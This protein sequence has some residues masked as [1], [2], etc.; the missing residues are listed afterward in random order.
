MSP[1]RDNPS[2]V[3]LWAFLGTFFCFMMGVVSAGVV[4][5]VASATRSDVLFL[6]API[7]YFGVPIIAYLRSRQGF[8]P[9][10]SKGFGI[11]LALFVGLTLL[12][13]VVICGGMLAFGK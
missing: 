9:D 11:G 7:A 10:R 12:L 6:L 2:E 5:A 1:A 3:L 8:S 13:P 4:V